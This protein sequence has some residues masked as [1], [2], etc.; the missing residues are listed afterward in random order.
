MQPGCHNW[1]FT[2]LLLIT[3]RGCQATDELLEAPDWPSKWLLVQVRNMFA[4]FTITKLLC[5]CTESPSASVCC[6]CL[7]RC[8][9]YRWS[10]SWVNINTFTGSKTERHAN[11]GPSWQAVTQH[12]FKMSASDTFFMFLPT[13]FQ[14]S[15]DLP[16][17]WAPR[18]T[19]VL[20]SSDNDDYA[21]DG[22]RWWQTCPGFLFQQTQTCTHRIRAV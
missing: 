17:W 6:C 5:P 9:T 1:C 14:S 15:P 20:P 21:G 8:H 12:K 16:W 13:H 18:R 7:A 2:C 11:C 4:T 22:W 3:A 10:C 19:V